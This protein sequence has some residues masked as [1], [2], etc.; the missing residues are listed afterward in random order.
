MNID[1]I[2]LGCAG[3]NGSGKRSHDREDD[4]SPL[5]PHLWSPDRLF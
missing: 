5:M 1:E 2:I 3:Q 4:L